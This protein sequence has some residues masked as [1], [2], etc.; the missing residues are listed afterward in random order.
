MTPYQIVAV[1][2]RLFAVWLAIGA[3]RALPSYF[4]ES[5]PGRGYALFISALTCALALAM[6]FFPLTIARK[7]LSRETA[8]V[9]GTATPDTW[10]AAGCS[11]IGL[12]ILT[13]AVPKIVYDLLVLNSTS[14]YDDT[15]Q[16]RHWIVYNLLEV[17]IGIWLVLGGMG[18]RKVFWWAQN[19]GTKKAL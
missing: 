8:E 2:L 18:F 11:L 17:A 12:W 9:R 1:A 16:I 6:W 4:V 19:A 10:L 14:G 15:S 13:T 7:L 3:L 5:Y